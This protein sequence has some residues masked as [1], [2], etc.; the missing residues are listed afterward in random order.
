MLKNKLQEFHQVSPRSDRRRGLLNFGGTILNTVF[1]T[2][3]ISDVYM[4]QDV[5][6]DLRSQNSDMSHSLS[7]QIT[8]EETRHDYE[9]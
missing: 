7:S 2:A 6:T 5:L 8:C 9:I 3:T 1:G 4:L